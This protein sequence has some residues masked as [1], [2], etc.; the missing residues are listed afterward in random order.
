ML[1]RAGR[2][3]LEDLRRPGAVLGAEHLGELVGRPDVELALDALAVG[4][5][6][7][8]EAT[9]GG[10]QLAQQEVG[11]LAGDPLAQRS[12]PPGVDA[13]Q[14][15]VVVE[16]L[17][18]VRDHPAPV[19]RVAR[20]AAAELVVDPAARHR[21]AG[22]VEHRV[23]GAR[24]RCAPR[25][26]AGTPAPSTAGTSARRRSRRGARRT[27]GRA[28]PTTAS[29]VSAPIR[30]VASARLLVEVLAQVAGDPAYVVAAVLP[31]VHQ[32]LQQLAEGRL[33]VPRLVGE[34]G[35]GEERVAVGVEDA[36]HRPA[37]LAGHRRGRLHV[38]RVDVR[39]LL[40]VDLDADE[41]LVE[42]RRGRLVLERLVRHHVAPVAGGVP[43]REQ[44]GHVAAR[45]PRRT[46]P[47]PTPT[48][49]PGCR[50]AGAGTARSRARGGSLPPP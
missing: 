44:D 43:D 37:A 4:V 24:R 35:A 9:L 7:R 42:V 16:H 33:P 46:P 47:A 23:R 29:S 13:Q 27:P 40:A 41:V 5:E 30:P 22:R 17:L 8:G 3:D 15:G 21:L 20:E 31:G 36:R 14:L 50:R 26:G 1:E 19:D 18:E 2:G 39:P 48:S 25:A 12:A 11:G 28:S 49:R 45:G 10:A 34:V 38:D 32:R 6:R